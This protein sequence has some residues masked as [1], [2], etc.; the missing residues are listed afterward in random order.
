MKLKTYILLTLII[1]VPASATHLTSLEKEYGSN[2]VTIQRQA[3]VE[4][5]KD[6]KRIFY[7]AWQR[8]NHYV[9]R[10]DDEKMIHMLR[11]EPTREANGLDQA[12]LTPYIEQVKRH[13]ELIHNQ[14]N[15]ENQKEIK[16]INESSS[17]E[18]QSKK[19]KPAY[20]TTAECVRKIKI[21]LYDPLYR[22]NRLVSWLSDSEIKRIIESGSRF[23]ARLDC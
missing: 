19:E 22:M 4:W 18:E 16:T 11:H 8:K 2:V 10:L 13:R 1:V 15:Q 3:M 9:S 12:N 21:T 5:V 23:N 7:D 14:T 6:N 20:S 17:E